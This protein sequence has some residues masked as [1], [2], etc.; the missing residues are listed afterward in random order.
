M[1]DKKA[2]ETAKLLV[3][4]CKDQNGCQNCVFRKYGSHHWECTIN[5][6]DLNE[7]VSN[8]EAKKKNHGYI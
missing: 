7:V 4:F 1:N 2:I 3:E 8:Y 6:F 5:A